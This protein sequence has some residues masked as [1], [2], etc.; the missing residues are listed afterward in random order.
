MAHQGVKGN[1]C[2]SN[3]ILITFDSLAAPNMS[4]Y[5]YL[6]N[7]TPHIDAFANESIVFKNVYANCNSSIPSLISILTGK[8]PSTH[9][10]HRLVSFLK[11]KIRF[12]NIVNVFKNNGYDTLAVW[13]T[14]WGYP[15]FIRHGKKLKDSGNSTG[16]S[17]IEIGLFKNLL[18][19]CRFSFTSNLPF[20]KECLTGLISQSLYRNMPKSSQHDKQSEWTN[21]SESTFTRA[22]EYLQMMR[23]PFFFWVHIYPPH[24]PY[25]PTEK[26]KYSY[27]NERTLDTFFVQRRYLNRHYSSELQPIIDKLKSC[28]D[29][30]I[31]STDDSFGSF[32][33][34]IKRQGYFKNSTI[35]ITSDHGEMFEKGYQ[36][37][38]GPYLYQPM[39]HIPL[40]IRM[41]GSKK[42]KVVACHAEQVDIAPTILD[43]LGLDIPHWME[44][45]SL[46]KWVENNSMS[47]KSKFSMNIELIK[48]G[49]MKDGSVAVIH[50]G[51]KLIYYLKDN[52]NE[53]YDLLNDPREE[54][55]IAD[56]K[57]KE[58]GTF[59]KLIVDRILTQ[60]NVKACMKTFS[61]IISPREKV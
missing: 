55:N 52:R 12:E 29:E 33:D 26:F 24:Q 51:R 15:W 58:V 19:L 13:G 20:W 36:G 8:Y 35:I 31:L 48:N 39:I 14:F 6:R 3:V 56:L 28:Y 30:H 2:P 5:G 42:R 32:L 17:E 40:I 54:I 45:E 49:G 27:L 50:E 43:M 41:P 25:L 10:H 57:R 59:K 1:P 47:D 11:D 7:T 53:M 23:S 44:G 38:D 18:S 60:P 21:S 61:G 46:R 34:S 4:L 9:K 16:D 37:H 22:I